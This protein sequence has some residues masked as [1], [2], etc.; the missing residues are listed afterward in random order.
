VRKVDFSRPI[1]DGPTDVGFDYFFGT[2]CCPTTDWL[3]AYIENDHVVEAPTSLARPKTRHWLEYEHFRTG[4]KAPGFD[5]RL[6][7]LVF[8]ERS[9]RFLEQHVRGD[10][11]RPFFL[12]HATQTAHLPAMPADQFVGKTQ[13]GPL[14]DFIFEFDHVVGEL[15]K[16]L[17]RIGVAQNTLVVVTSD[18]G[19]EIVIT[20]LRTEYGHDS[21]RPWRGLKRDNWE[22]GHRI[23][24][25]V[26]WPGRI[27]PGTLNST[28]LCLTDLMATCAGVIGLGLP[29]GAGEDSY[30]MLPALLNQN[31][32]TPVR[33]YT[34]HQ[35]IRND[36]AI[37]QGPWKLLDHRGSGGNDYD[38]EVLEP[39]RLPNT[40]PEAP[41][42]LY[43]LLEDPGETRN[44]Y[45]KRPEV[46]A[47]LKHRL[48]ECKRSGRSAPES[49]R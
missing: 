30:N 8:L 27:Q 19:P 26:R 28:T 7:D 40:A 47:E 14:G 11:N 9:I 49:W 20:R 24:F 12:Y 37:R 1:H 32:E 44:L 36:L 48:E 29:P 6:V 10:P 42:Q 5:F 21:A 38:S 45:L 13:A 41:G 39:Y 35:T 46:V 22:G 3:Y 16:C 33:G 2:V 15:L 43:N 18:N 31:T 17:D 4:L 23:P 34:L 25:I